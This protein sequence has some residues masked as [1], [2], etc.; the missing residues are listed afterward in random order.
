MT[1]VDRKMRLDISTY[2]NREIACSCGRIHFCPIEQVAV[3]PGAL[4]QLP[5]MAR[6]YSHVFLVA[7]RNTWAVCGESVLSLI[8]ERVCGVHVYERE[9]ALVPEERAV[10]ELEEVL[11]R[12][13]DLVLGVGSGVI[14]DLCKYVAWRRGVGSAIVATAPSMDGYASSGAAM[15]VEGMKVTYTVRPPRFILA[16]VDVVKD[17]PLEMIRAGYGDIIGK[18]SSLNDWKLSR[19]IRGEYF[20]G[21]ICG[22][23]QEVTDNIRGLAGRIMSRDAGA[24]EYLTKALILIGITLSLVGSTRPGSGSEHHLSHFFEI[25]GL[26]RGEPHFCHGIDVGYATQVTAAMRERIMSLDKPVFHRE[27]AEERRT[28]WRRVYGRLA[29]EVEALQSSACSYER[30]DTRLYEEK[31]PEIR[32]ILS[33]C[34]TAAEI[35]EMLAQAGYRPELFS[36]MY[37]KGK[38]Q[39]AVYYGK[40]LK[41]RYSVL[42]LYYDLF[43][44]LK[45]VEAGERN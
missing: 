9:H 13:A 18:Y 21:E 7:D 25:V 2:C 24:I 23:V 36:Q 1:Q 3:F 22:L 44:G 27:G 39:D 30:D 8:R 34:P 45:D 29:D 32:A 10:R 5:A 16:D 17:A 4:S 35:G 43:S 19:L 12:D 26:I 20:C 38:L 31:W 40:D 11:P 37:P 41:D 28:E 15:I 42:W 33:E 6:R 14:N